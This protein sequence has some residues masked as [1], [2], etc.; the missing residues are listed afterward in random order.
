[1]DRVVAPE[2][3]DHLPPD[4]DAARRSRT[5]LRRI[6]AVMGNHRWFRGELSKRLLPGDR[7]LEIGAGDGSLRAIR[8]AGVAWDGLDLCPAPAG[9]PDDARWHRTD[10]LHFDGWA[11][12]SVVIGNLFFHHF[13]APELARLGAAIHSN[14][15]LF[16]ASEPIRSRCSQAG[17]QLLCLLLR[18]HPVTRHDARVS[19]E[20]GFRDEELPNALGLSSA[21]SWRRRTSHSWRGGCRLIAT[22]L[23]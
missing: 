10:A 22:R 2:I 7:L 23:A 9:W 5:D 15:R 8:P 1:M 21:S 14:A 17:L 4:S 16:L 11:G 12:Y 3:L 18:A 13:T 6:N 19:I 20:A